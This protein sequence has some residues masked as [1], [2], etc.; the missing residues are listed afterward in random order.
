ME[1]NGHLRRG[2]GRPARAAVLGVVLGALLLPAHALAGT[3]TWS[4]PRDFSSATE[5]Y[6][7]G[8]EGWSYA[9]GSGLPLVYSN[10]FNGGLRGWTNDPASPIA[11][12]A[13]NPTGSTVFG[14]PPGQLAMQPRPGGSIDLEWTSP[15]SGTVAISG[16]VT[17]VH[18]HAG[19][20]F[21]WFLTSS[22]SGAIAQGSHSETLPLKHV[23]VERGATIYLVIYNT[24]AS[25]SAQYGTAVVRLQIQAQ[26][27]APVVTLDR[28]GP[29]VSGEQPRFAGSASTGFGYSG[30]V[31][32]RVYRRAVAPANLEEIVDAHVAGGRYSVP[33]DPRLANGTYVAQADQEDR[34]GGRSFSNPVT[35]VLD[36]PAPKVTL[37]PLPRGPLTAARPTFEGTAGRLRGDDATVHVAIYRGNRV[38]GTPFLLL[39]AR[40]QGNG[41]YSVRPGPGRGLPDGAYTAVAS[42]QG[43]GPTGSSVLRR[44]RVKFNPPAVTLDR[45]RSGSVLGTRRPLFSGQAGTAQGDFRTVTVFLYRGPRATGRAVGTLRVTA[46]GRSW[47]G[48]WPHNLANGLYTAVATQSDDARHTAITPARTFQIT[49]R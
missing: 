45:P 3:F 2:T 5:G 12:V 38:A 8:Q 28:I 16:E 39:S 42:Q 46:R 31:T 43:P 25:C 30:T 44:F 33:A 49:A 15:L 20:G 47:S 7:P 27:P 17:Q 19:C 26:T 18:A 4:M 41:R 6:K 13:I 22:Q 34:S 48:S 10:G 36:N 29:R 24:S 37:N 35:F 11:F 23:S 32:V 1:E 40:R 21:V 9:R 14:V